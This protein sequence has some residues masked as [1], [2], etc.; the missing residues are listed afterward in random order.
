MKIAVRKPFTE[1]RLELGR[2][3]LRL[4]LDSVFKFSSVLGDVALTAVLV[5]L[6]LGASLTPLALDL[7]FAL[8]PF[9][10]ASLP[11]GDFS[12]AAPDRFGFPMRLLAL[13]VR[14]R[15]LGVMVM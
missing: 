12:D 6:E 4:R 10:A 3:R 1:V 2:L 14:S 7:A 15:C 11:F 5:D 8:G 9:F 13:G